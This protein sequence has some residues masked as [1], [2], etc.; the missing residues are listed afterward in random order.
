MAFLGFKSH[1]MIG[2]I[3]KRKTKCESR[4]AFMHLHIYMQAAQWLPV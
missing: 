3:T 4:K 2:D 1:C